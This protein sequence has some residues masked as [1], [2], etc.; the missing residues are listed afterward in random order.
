[1]GALCL[2]SCCTDWA[3]SGE[4]PPAPP[5]PPATPAPPPAPHAPAERMCAR[6]GWVPRACAPRRQRGLGLSRAPL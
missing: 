6:K 5:A 4:A 2:G 1:M 3:A